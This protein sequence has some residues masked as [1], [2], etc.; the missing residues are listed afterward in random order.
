MQYDNTNSGI[1]FINDK[2][3][4]D[5]SPDYRGSINI[6]GEEYW[7]SGWVN[8]GKTEKLMG[9]KYLSLKASLKVSVD[10][11]KKQNDE[12]KINDFHDDPLPF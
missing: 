12:N 3:S 9:K 11:Q 5:K 4:G 10:D 7:I 8:I 1:L 6:A 2:K